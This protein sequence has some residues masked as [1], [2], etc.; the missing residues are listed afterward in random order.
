MVANG[1]P[2]EYGNSKLPTGQQSL[3]RINIHRL[4]CCLRIDGIDSD[5]SASG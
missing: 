2:P 4:T 5:S 3:R 1:Q